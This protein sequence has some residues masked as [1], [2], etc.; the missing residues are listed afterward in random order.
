MLL[1]DNTYCTNRILKWYNIFAHKCWPIWW[2]LVID[3]MC[4]TKYVAKASNKQ[5]ICKNMPILK[6]FQQHHNITQTNT[7]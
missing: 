1:K 5:I 6:A 3:E 4:Y 7:Q 2:K